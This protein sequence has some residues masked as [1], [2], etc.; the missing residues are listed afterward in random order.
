M[1]CC[2][3]SRMAAPFG[4]MKANARDDQVAKTDRHGSDLVERPVLCRMPLSELENEAEE[5]AR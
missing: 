4:T 3:Q 1:C 2:P 5:H